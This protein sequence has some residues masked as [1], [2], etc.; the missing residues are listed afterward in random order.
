MATDTIRMANAM[1][2]QVGSV[3]QNRTGQ[4]GRNYHCDQ[5][6]KRIGLVNKGHFA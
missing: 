1:V 4:D 3:S 2:A 6:E 5:K